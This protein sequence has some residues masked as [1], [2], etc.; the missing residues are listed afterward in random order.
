[1]TIATTTSTTHFPSAIATTAT[2]TTSHSV[3]RRQLASLIEICH[4]KISCN[5]AWVVQELTEMT[6][7]GTYNLIL[8]SPFSSTSHC[9]CCNN[10][11]PEWFCCNLGSVFNSFRNFA[12]SPPLTIFDCLINVL[13]VFVLVSIHANSTTIIWTNGSICFVSRPSYS[14]PIPLH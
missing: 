6:G 8:F 13:R 11:P 5:G 1:M 7:E 9:D 10:Y 12:A 2:T 4:L 3:D 14:C